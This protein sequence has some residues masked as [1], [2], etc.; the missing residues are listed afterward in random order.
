MRY[1]IIEMVGEKSSVSKFVQMGKLKRFFN[2]PSLTREEPV[3]VI[4]GFFVD[5]K[6]LG[7]YIHFDIGRFDDIIHMR[8][9]IAPGSKIINVL[10]MSKVSE[11]NMNPNQ[12]DKV[13]IRWFELIPYDDKYYKNIDDYYMV[14]NTDEYFI[15]GQL[16]GL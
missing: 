7:E 3:K 15:T 4:H 6:S 1:M 9:I 14:N 8:D 12:E 11:V 2:L 13:F 10:V 16:Y 5:K